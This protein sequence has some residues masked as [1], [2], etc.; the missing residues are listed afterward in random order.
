M[1]IA[2]A[3][4]SAPSNCASVGTINNDII[5]GHHALVAKSGISNLSPGEG[6]KPAYKQLSIK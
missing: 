5:S 3:M 1:P 2:G 4:A 6:T